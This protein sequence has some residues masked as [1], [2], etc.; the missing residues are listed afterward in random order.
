MKRTPSQNTNPR[1]KKLRRT[2]GLAAL[3]LFGV[4]L[5]GC[6]VLAGLFA[7]YGRSLPDVHSLRTRWNPPQTTRILARDGSV[8]AE[9]FIE[10]R[11][12]VPLESL[13]ENMVKALLA[14]ED[15][16]FY[17]HQGLDWPGLVRALWINVRHGTLAQGASTITQQVVKNVLLTPERT[18]S[19]KVREVL[20]ARRIEQELGKNEILFLYVN[21]IAFG[22]GRNGVEEAARFY[23]GEHVGAAHPGRVRA[24]RGHPQEPHALLSEA[25]PRRRAPPS[26]L[27]PRADGREALRHARP[28][29]RRRRRARAPRVDPR[30]RRQRMPRG[31]RPRAPHALAG[32]GRRLAPPRRIHRLHDARPGAP[33][34]CARGRHART[35]RSST[36]ATDTAGRSLR[37][38]RDAPPRAAT[39]SAQSVRPP[40][41]GCTPDTS[42]QAS[43][44]ARK[45]P[46]KEPAAAA[47]STSASEPR[48]GASRGRPPTVTRNRSRP[49][50]SRPWAPW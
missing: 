49:R 43:S 7:Y 2:L 21:H 19:R 12:V 10:R 13:P 41:G 26:P 37:P 1:K 25:Q 34:R 38:A 35:A 20:L 29:R 50:S 36:R 9:L 24:P 4:G 3:G 31:G 39:S 6:L 27:D 48:Q 22:H 45:I 14:A 15:A 33:A 32:R 16:D 46:P 44:S 28:G 18:L 40:M 30:R 42:T 17:E 8:L 23:F 5:T 47:P 11:T